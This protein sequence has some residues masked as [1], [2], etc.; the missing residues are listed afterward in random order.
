MECVRLSHVR[1][2]VRATVLLVLAMS[3]STLNALAQYAY[4]DTSGD[5]NLLKAKRGDVPS[6]VSVLD[7]LESQFGINFS[8][9]LAVVE[10]KGVPAYEVFPDEVER[11]LQ[12]LLSPLNLQHKPRVRRAT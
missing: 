8:Y 4:T 3:L 10:E 2:Y 7:E 12:N 11:T 5:R 1:R 9:E 6:L